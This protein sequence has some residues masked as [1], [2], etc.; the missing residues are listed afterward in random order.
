[1][2]NNTNKQT[3]SLNEAIQY[4]N[5][6][7]K[8][9]WNVIAI[10][11][12]KYPEKLNK[13]DGKIPVNKGWE[14]QRFA[15]EGHTIWMDEIPALIFGGKPR[16]NRLP[17]ATNTGLNAAGLFII[18][19]DSFGDK[20]E[21]MMQDIENRFGKTIVR[22][23]DN[24]SF[25]F[26]YRTDEG[27]AKQIIGNDQEK[28]HLEILSD[29]E[30][31]IIDGFHYSG[32][33]IKWRDNSPA[34]FKKSD[35]PYVSQEQMKQFLSETYEKYNCNFCTIHGM[36]KISRSKKHNGETRERETTYH[37]SH[38]T[39]EY[40]PLN[41]RDLE[42]LI[43]DLDNNNVIYYTWLN[44]ISAI[45][46]IT[47]GSN[48]GY[49]LADMYSQK[50]KK[51]DAQ[52]TLNKWND[53]LLKYPE[54]GFL[55]NE[56][57]MQ[58]NG[59][60]R[61]PSALENI[62]KSKERHKGNNISHGKF[63]QKDN[64]LFYG[65]DETIDAETGEITESKLVFVSGKFEYIGRVR[66]RE[67]NGWGHFIK[68]I[69]E[70][71][72]EHQRVILD[73]ELISMN[74]DFF[75]DLANGGLKFGLSKQANELLK[76]YFNEYKSDIIITTSKKTGWIEN[77]YLFPD[78]SK[79]GDAHI[80]LE[81]LQKHKN[82]TKGTLA[83]WQQSIGRLSNGNP[84]IMFS[85]C[86]ALA[87]P[88]LDIVNHDNGGFH[89]FGRSRTG[90][91][92]A[93]KVATSVFG[94]PRGAWKATENGITAN[95]IRANDNTLFLDE[96]GE[97]TGD[98]G[99]VVYA[100]GNGCEKL[101]ANQTGAAKHVETFRLLYL[102]TGEYAFL[103]QP[104]IKVT[105]GQLG[106]LVDIS[107]DRMPLDN[108]HEHTSSQK[109]VDSLADYSL[110]Y[111][112]SAGRHFIE[113]LTEWRTNCPSELKSFIN[114][115]IS[116][117]LANVPSN[118]DNQVTSIA[119][120][121][122]ICAV[123]GELAIDWQILPWDKGAAWNAVVTAF[124]AALDNRGH[125]HSIEE[126]QSI[127]CVR[128]F[129][130]QNEQSRF[131]NKNKEPTDYQPI[132]RD[133]AGYKRGMTYL[134]YPKIFQDEICEGK[135]YRYVA[136]QLCDKKLLERQ[137]GGRHLTKTVTIDGKSTRFYCISKAI[138]SDN[139]DD[140]AYL[141]AKLITKTRVTASLTL[142]SNNENNVEAINKE[143]KWNA[144]RERIDIMQANKQKSE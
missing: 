97:F 93:I 33:E 36:P 17:F 38:E 103:K 109:F 122:A 51:Y 66:D 13:S 56:I 129:I 9:G 135:D 62:K 141:E 40:A 64:G 128:N 7:L 14:Y 107:L 1:M 142:V 31:L 87:G 131:V 89:I 111:F 139:G 76:K 42:A 3:R 130:E 32:N 22:Y 30:Q 24:N 98:A 59:E 96:M 106:R 49:R 27:I 99:K 134:I 6:C 117:F 72:V 78:G 53:N 20:A 39:K 125:T 45:K 120:R 57:Q 15:D 144:I 115:R 138:L 137:P 11:S 101:R 58:C 82:M 8:N 119:K 4:R 80:A 112:G 83:E 86:V 52:Y 63:H 88:L 118:A 95:G 114:G 70:S 18:D 23:R 143:K 132:L 29:G 19:G 37:E 61:S 121:F 54:S 5:A 50:S 34:N 68:W 77:S 105:A 48:D 28:Y 108:L 123:A 75:V 44:V 12:P 127:A 73:R 124:G 71:K 55:I 116:E 25:A 21:Q 35:I 140:D 90:K 113:K 65:D 100:L 92:T 47:S 81:S 2:T 60:W 41:M 16:K 85:I 43:N 91:T 102:S 110:E 79:S 126:E 133:I 69:D 10:N 26:V 136:R 46:N 94:M 74:N 104:K 67:S 84:H